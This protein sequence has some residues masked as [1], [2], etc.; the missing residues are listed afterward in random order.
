MNDVLSKANSGYRIKNE[1][2]GDYDSWSG[3]PRFYSEDIT[4][5]NL[6]THTAGFDYRQLG[7]ASS[8][9]INTNSSLLDTLTQRMPP[10]SKF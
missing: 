6:I 5:E 8:T 3:M 9:P 1:Q 2:I 10:R 4:I 7:I